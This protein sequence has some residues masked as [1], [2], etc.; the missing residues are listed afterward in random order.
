MTLFGRTCGLLTTQTVPFAAI[1]AGALGVYGVPR[2]TFD[3]D[4]LVR[5]VRV[6]DSSFWMNVKAEV[7]V[8]HG[9]ADDPL[10]G[11]VRLEEQDER[12]VDVIV[13]RHAWQDGMLGRAQSAA[14]VGVQVPVVTP[15]DLVLLKL[16]AGG[17]QDRWDIQQLLAV[18]DVRADV[19]ERV[20]DLPADA[21]QL[22][23][24]LSRE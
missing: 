12:P 22:W 14:I 4:L 20:V 9:D 10:R 24:Q 23:E 15:A 17:V 19:D 3:L 7:D 16:F 18:V 6:L 8:R 1:G 21:R 11:V 2:S 13:G 5:D